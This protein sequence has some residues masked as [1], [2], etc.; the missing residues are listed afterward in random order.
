MIQGLQVDNENETARLP[1]N[2]DQT[3][4]WR[5]KIMHKVWGQE[6]YSLDR[7]TDSPVVQISSGT[8]LFFFV[9]DL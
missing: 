5:P 3:M 8:T 7:E 9:V 2:S 1:A 6:N 4:C